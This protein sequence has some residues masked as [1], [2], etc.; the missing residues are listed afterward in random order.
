MTS[1]NLVVPPEPTTPPPPSLATVSLL[2]KTIPSSHLTVTE[3]SMVAATATTTSLRADAAA[4]TA[5]ATTAA[6]L[7][8]GWVHRHWTT[9]TISQDEDGNSDDDN[10]CP[11][12]YEKTVSYDT[13]ASIRVR[14]WDGDQN[15][16]A[17]IASESSPYVTGATT[18]TTTPANGK[19]L[20]TEEA[21]PFDCMVACLSLCGTPMDEES[22]WTAAAVHE[23][24]CR[25][26]DMAATTTTASPLP[27]VLLLIVP[28]TATTT[29]CQMTNNT[30][31]PATTRHNMEHLVNELRRTKQI[32][33]GYA[34]SIGSDEDNDT[35]HL[36]GCFQAIVESVLADRATAAAATTTTLDEPR[37]VDSLLGSQT[38]TPGCCCCCC[39]TP[40]T[41][42]ATATSSLDKEPTVVQVV[43]PPQLLERPGGKRKSPPNPVVWTT[44]VKKPKNTNRPPAKVTPTVA[45]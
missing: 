45:R 26:K 21:A 15:G 13:K 3:D 37:Q 35:C 11:G 16:P 27:V 22:T 42:A 23:Q 18:T 9:T 2:V 32:V 39:T 31:L 20:G 41:D 34:I 12:W 36:D 6:T 29:R 1:P 7:C 5:T 10:D 17:D 43:V 19:K 8:R 25:F 4:A 40:T 28:S 30:V 38:H 14:L 44:A 24:V 33:A